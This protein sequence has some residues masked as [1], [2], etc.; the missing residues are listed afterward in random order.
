MLN[1]AQVSVINYSTPHLLRNQSTINGL[2]LL[3]RN[4]WNPISQHIFPLKRTCQVHCYLWSLLASA[5]AWS[6]NFV[7]LPPKWNKLPTYDLCLLGSLVV[8]VTDPL[9]LNAHTPNIKNC[10]FPEIGVYLPLPSLL[11]NESIC[12]SMV[13]GSTRFP[14]VEQYG[15]SAI[16]THVL[17]I[18]FP[19]H[20]YFL[21]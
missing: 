6:V 14:K 17:P 15:G 8:P 3:C 4:P 10:I 16:L 20:L 1:K 2:Y 9:S 13:F 11:E 7:V 18:R 21:K 19:L 5:T 12:L